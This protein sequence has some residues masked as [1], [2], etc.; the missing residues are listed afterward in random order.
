VFFQRYH[1][2]NQL[3]AQRDELKSY[4]A[5]L[6]EADRRKDEFLATLAHELRN[7]LAPIRNGL[8]ILRTSP[9]AP[10]AEEIRDVM[11]R[12]L[13]H[14]VRLVDDLLDVS[15]VSQGKIDLRKAR[16]ALSDVIKTARREQPI[17]HGGSS[18]T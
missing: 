2:R 7:P 8:D 17:D 12:Q 1:Q 4:A 9:T 15:R 18:R 5:A 16:I 10:N 13:S 3:A 6:T 14:L 11:D